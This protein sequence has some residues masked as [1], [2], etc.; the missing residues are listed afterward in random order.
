MCVH[1][2]QQPF[3]SKST[4][5]FSCHILMKILHIGYHHTIIETLCNTIL[6]ILLDR[7]P[8]GFQSLFNILNLMY[9][10]GNTHIILLFLVFRQRTPDS[11]LM[12][13]LNASKRLSLDEIFAS[14]IS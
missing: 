6:P 4:D 2:L 1:L 10:I 8:L 3:K 5:T 9:K 11:P 14:F 7:L 13:L 12:F